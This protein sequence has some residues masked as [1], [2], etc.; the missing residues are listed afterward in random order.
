MP[1]RL[2]T[3]LDKKRLEHNREKTKVLRF[4]RMGKKGEWEKG[5]MEKRENGKDKLG[6][7]RK[8]A[9]R[10]EIIQIFELYITKE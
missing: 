5:K 1:E 7:E 10:G 8:R 3:Y 2:E 6:I 9:K 4:G